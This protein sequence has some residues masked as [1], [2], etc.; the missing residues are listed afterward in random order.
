MRILPHKGL[1]ER[2]GLP[3]LPPLP[4]WREAAPE[5]PAR[6]H[7][8][9]VGSV[10]AEPDAIQPSGLPPQVCALAPR[11][12]YFHRHQLHTEYV[13]RLEQVLPL[14]AVLCLF[15]CT[16][17]TRAWP[18]QSTHGWEFPH[19]SEDAGLPLC[20]ANDASNGLLC[21]GRCIP[22]CACQLRLHQRS[23]T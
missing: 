10:H 1:S 9:E 2:Q 6:A 7:V 14:T 12:R 17:Y 23:S 11:F 5:A 21:R 16:F 19:A 13:Q 4:P 20:A 3:L 15:S 22:G 18:R 8:R